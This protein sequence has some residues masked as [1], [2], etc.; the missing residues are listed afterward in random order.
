M[1]IVKGLFSIVD[2]VEDDRYITVTGLNS[3]QFQ[4]DLRKMWGTTRVYNYMM[5]RANRFRMVFPKFFALEM[6][7]M[8]DTM[9]L[10][11]HR[12]VIRTPRRKLIAVLEMLN[13]ETWLSSIG[14]GKKREYNERAWSLFTKRPFD[15]QEDFVGDYAVRTAQYQLNGLLLAAAAGSGKTLTNMFLS[16]LLGNRWTIIVAPKPSIY[17]VWETSLNDDFKSVPNYWIADKG[18]RAPSD[19]EYFVTHYEALEKT[20]VELER[21]GVTNPT[22][23]L[24]ECHNLNEIRSERTMRFIRMCKL[25]K[26]RDVI[27]ASGTPLKAMGAEMVPLLTTIDPMFTDEVRDRFIKIF[28]SKT[29]RAGDVLAHRLGTVRYDVPKEVYQKNAG[30]KHNLI[31]EDVLVKVPNSDGYTLDSVKDK[32]V[33]AVMERSKHY[34][35]NFSH[36][37]Q[38]WMAGIK[39]IEQRVT[40][41][42]EWQALDTY[43][44]N[45]KTIRKGYDPVM[46]KDIAKYCND[47]EKKTIIPSLPPEMKETFRNAKSVVKYVNLKIQGEVLGNVLGRLRIQCNVDIA[48]AIDIVPLIDSATKKTVLFSSYQEVADVLNERLIGLGYRTMLIHGNSMYDVARGV[49]IFKKDVDVNPLVTTFKTLSTAV[50]LITASTGIMMNAPF[51]D[52]E[53]KQTLARLDRI[54]QDTDVTFYTAL[55]DTQSEANISTRSKDILEWSKEQVAILMGEEAKGTIDLEAHDVLDIDAMES[56]P[57]VISDDR[58]V[59][60]I[61]AYLQ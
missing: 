10:D 21:L 40:N 35:E 27:W 45:I 18:G 11:E 58:L 19:T 4:N 12:K 34:K 17:E 22:V 53:R 44:A 14:T 25:T 61:P 60:S 9:L 43:M 7:Y 6:R 59:V 36:Y 5:V 15:H 48:K 1:S 13:S 37:E 41:S 50:P 23:V 26:A 38:Q 54:G 3:D 51:R 42:E 30:S 24:D 55:L 29:V 57:A 49:P 16:K 8:L 46:H 2:V 28:G 52:Y 20:I 31:Q 56:I 33:T 32:M 39:Y 47:Y